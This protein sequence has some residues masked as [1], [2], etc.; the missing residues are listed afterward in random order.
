MPHC[1][2]LGIHGLLNVIYEI[3]LTL[4]EHVAGGRIVV[5]D[6]EPG[7]MLK[8]AKSVLTGKLPDIADS[9]VQAIYFVLGPGNGLMLDSQRIS[10][11]MKGVEVPG[12]Q[13][14]LYHE[15]WI[16]ETGV[17]WEYNVVVNEELSAVYKAVESVI[18]L[19]IG[20]FDDTIAG[21]QE[22]IYICCEVLVRF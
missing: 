19:I 14:C 18:E 2:A 10:W 4:V 21:E 20:I 16:L 3:L 6:A 22:P 11:N 7:I 8:P 9:A 5:A 13:E 15:G 17:G 12:R 1:A